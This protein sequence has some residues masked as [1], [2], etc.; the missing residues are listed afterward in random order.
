[1]SLSYALG[2]QLLVCTDLIRKKLHDERSPLV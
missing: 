1:V 2:K